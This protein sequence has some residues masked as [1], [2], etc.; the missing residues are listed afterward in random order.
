L[1]HF[2]SPITELIAEYLGVVAWVNGKT[3]VK[4]ETLDA[5]G[6]VRFRCA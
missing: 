3:L 5:F 4:K 1:D 2:V 6:K